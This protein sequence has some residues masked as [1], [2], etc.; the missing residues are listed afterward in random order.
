MK[1]EERHNCENK[2]H[3]VHNIVR[4]SAFSK[5]K[6]AAFDTTFYPTPG[7][8]D[9]SKHFNA[10]SP[11]SY[12][13]TALHQNVKQ[14]S[15]Y[16]ITTGT[17]VIGI[18][19][20]SG[21]VLAADM[22][23]SYG[24]TARFPGVSRT[25]KVNSNTALVASG[26]YADYQMLKEYLDSMMIENDIEDDGHEY[27]PQALFSY[28]RMLMYHKRSKFDPLWNTLV[29]GGRNQGK[30]FLG[31]VDKLGVAYEEN[32][33]AT[34]YGAYIAIP[35]IRKALEDKPNLSQIEAVKLVVDCLRVLYYR[36]ARSINKFEITIVTDGGVAMETNMVA[37]TNWE[38]AHMV[39]GYE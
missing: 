38:I 26:D 30:S 5:I 14:L 12:R 25:M 22:L 29:I 13:Q 35:L 31:Y 15:Q 10:L 24:S 39:K 6:M 27:T 9:S 20:D 2:E 8:L 37:E 18:K 36:D 16:P 32:C 17:S 19:F 11:P 34:G 1:F 4:K 28:L 7:K 33:I 23:G 3:T 21:V